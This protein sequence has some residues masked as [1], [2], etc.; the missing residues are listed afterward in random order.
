MFKEQC[1]C[2]FSSFFRQMT[3]NSTALY[4][5]SKHASTLACVG[6]ALGVYSTG[7]GGGIAK[8]STHSS[9]VVRQMCAN[10]VTSTVTMGRALS[11]SRHD[12]AKLQFNIFWEI[13][14]YP[15]HA[16]VVDMVQS[17]PICHLS[18]GVNVFSYF[19]PKGEKHRERSVGERD[20]LGCNCGVIV[21]RHAGNFETGG[22]G[23][24]FWIFRTLLGGYRVR[25]HDHHFEV[26]TQ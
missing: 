11:D 19:R 17:T 4:T 3:F 23:R 5:L 21:R 7:S 13:G 14:R 22:I 16:D 18:A 25:R 12:T 6:P 1:R 8:S 9:Q 2:D 26:G 20:R 15:L 10:T 24:M